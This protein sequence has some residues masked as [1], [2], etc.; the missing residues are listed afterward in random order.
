M[1]R[2]PLGNWLPARLP[3]L[4]QNKDKLT[5]VA[6]KYSALG[7][8]YQAPKHQYRSSL[9]KTFQAGLI[10]V[11]SEKDRGPDCGPSVVVHQPTWLLSCGFRWK[12]CR[13]VFSTGNTRF[14]NLLL[15][16]IFKKKRIYFSVC[17]CVCVCVYAQLYA[18][19]CRSDMMI[20]LVDSKFL[21]FIAMIFCTEVTI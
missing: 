5:K 9:G 20:Y 11:V 13:L 1:D 17:V 10:T 4:N 2:A 21:F 18:L 16:Y 19:A 6:W 8:T 15:G 14:W 12:Q 7:G 3:G